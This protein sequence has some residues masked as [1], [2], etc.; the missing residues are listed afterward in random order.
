M[1]S[2][3]DINDFKP[4][5]KGSHALFS[6]TEKH[7]TYVGKNPNGKYV[8]QFKVDGDVFPKKVPPDR[9]DYLLLDDTD[10]YAYYIE[11]KGSDIM[12]AIQQIECS[13]E[14]LHPSP[15]IKDYKI[16]CRIVYHTSTQEVTCSDAIRWKK[17][18]NAVITSRRYEEK[19]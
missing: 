1:V 14:R 6:M 17:R 9:C 12:W 15:S 18:R 11:L 8:R 4:C 10:H 3:M 2:D 5:R 16:R 7:C 19:L 13:I